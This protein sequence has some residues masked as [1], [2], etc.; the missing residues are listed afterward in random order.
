[1]PPVRRP[2]R[3]RTGWPS[4]APRSTSRLAV[5][6]TTQSARHVPDAADGVPAPEAGQELDVLV[7]PHSDADAAV[8]LDRAA[9][10]EREQLAERD[11]DVEPPRCRR[12][13][14]R[15]PAWLPRSPAAGTAR[16]LLRARRPRP[17]AR[18][19]GS[20][21]VEA[22]DRP[23]DRARRPRA[24]AAS[25]RPASSWRTRQ[26]HASNKSVEPVDQ[27]LAVESRS[28]PSDRCS[29]R[30]RSGWRKTRRGPRTRTFAAGTP[31]AWRW[32]ARLE[33]D[34]AEQH[35]EV[36]D[37]WLMAHQPRDQQVVDELA[38]K[39]VGELRR[40]AA[41]AA[42]RGDG[43]KRGLDAVAHVRR[44]PS[45]ISFC[46]P[47]CAW[48]IGVR[49]ASSAAGTAVKSQPISSRKSWNPS[50]VSSAATSGLSA[51]PSC[52]TRTSSVSSSAIRPTRR[53]CCRFRSIDDRWVRLSGI[54]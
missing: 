43:F 15:S 5:L 37:A 14:A 53:R 4:A 52:S 32:P 48:P 3:A 33:P 42:E 11:L 47:P 7:G 49:S 40:Q 28:V 22:R 31:D 23:P 30:T 13:S 8:E 34:D 44:C 27:S 46:A 17:R 20:R 16:R 12:A 41:A 38:R 50:V 10:A 35:A 6:P 25:P 24:A 39:L 2:R 18:R 19:T 1:M 26:S 9:D 36:S 51:S 29:S 45:V 21:S 54:G